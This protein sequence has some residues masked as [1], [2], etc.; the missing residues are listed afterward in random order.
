MRAAAGHVQV[1][2]SCPMSH[3]S[4]SARTSL[5]RVSILIFI[6]AFLVG[7]ASALPALMGLAAV[8]WAVHLRTQRP[9]ELSRR[10]WQDSIHSV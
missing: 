10:F 7:T 1:R 2:S 4:N 8:S 9:R 6:D 3:Q 5:Q